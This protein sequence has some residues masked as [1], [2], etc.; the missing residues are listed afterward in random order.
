YEVSVPS[1]SWHFSG[2]VG[3]PV[4]N[5]TV[6]SGADA[7]GAYSEI[8]FDF[9]SDAARHASIRSYAAQPDVVFTVSYPSAGPN[10]FPFPNWSQYPRNLDHLTFSGIF[11]PPTFN[12]F[13]NE[14]P[15]VFFDPSYNT[16]ILSPLSNFMTASTA[17]GPK[18]ELASGIAPEIAALPQ[19]FEHRTLLVI[20][21]GIN[22]AF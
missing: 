18:G 16:F 22:H 12:N 3:Y 4:L 7:V 14:S 5:V 6:A 17:W 20:E 19:G 9:Q 1:L 11:A 2:N 8:G 13:S 10:T 21:K 15:W